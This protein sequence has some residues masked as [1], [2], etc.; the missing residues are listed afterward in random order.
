MIE[1]TI[2][3]NQSLDIKISDIAFEVTH[4]LLLDSK[5]ENPPTYLID[6]VEDLNVVGNILSADKSEIVFLRK[7]LQTLT[8]DNFRDLYFFY[9]YSNLVS[10]MNN[11]VWYLET[12]I[13]KNNTILE[14]EVATNIAYNM[15]RDN[16]NK[17]YISEMTSIAE[18]KLCDIEENIVKN[19]LDNIFKIYRYNQDMDIK[20]QELVHEGVC[21]IFF[22]KKNGNDISKYP[23]N[24][25]DCY[26]ID[27][28][29][30]FISKENNTILYLEKIFKTLK[31]SEINK[32]FYDYISCFTDA[33]GSLIDYLEENIKNLNI[34]FTKKVARK[35]AM[36]MMANGDDWQYISDVTNIS[37]NELEIYQW[38]MDRWNKQEIA[39][40]N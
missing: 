37:I 33:L 25:L 4:K 30:D 26:D 19:R 36:R 1:D 15:L 17:K 8:H 23:I 6:E 29:G 20:I 27:E 31:H 40:K 16:K 5:Y 7:E 35:I 24:L 12:K 18:F 22:S 14:D 10:M 28:V 39:F 21:R 2:L 34:E 3:R 13:E 32:L 9:T 38:F 11:L